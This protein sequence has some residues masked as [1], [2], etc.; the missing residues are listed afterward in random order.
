MN[1]YFVNELKASFLL[2]K[3]KSRKPT[4]IYL[5]VYLGKK[6]YKFSLKVRVYPDQWSNKK[7]KAFISNILSELDNSNNRIVNEKINEYTERF[8]NFKNYL[9]NY[10][11]EVH[12]RE[13]IL[14]RYFKN[15][16]KIW[17]NE[18]NPFT[19]MITD[20]YNRVKSTSATNMTKV[21][22][23]FEDYCKTKEI[24]TLESINLNFL[25]GYREKLK[26]LPGKRKNTLITINAV[27]NKMTVLIGALKNAARLGFFDYNM[28]NI[29]LY[30]PLPEKVKQY[31][32]QIAL[33]LEEIKRI[34]E[35][36]LTGTYKEIRDAFI[37]QSF[38]GQ[39]FGDVK[40][41]NNTFIRIK[42]DGK[43]FLQ[44][45][46]QKR[47]HPIYIEVLPPV[48]QIID[49]NM[50][51]HSP[52]TANDYLKKIA[53]LAEIKGEHPYTTHTKNG[54]ETKSIPRYKLISTH[55]ARRFFIT[56]AR[57]N[58]VP[59]N[60]IM[61]ITGLKDKDMLERYDKLSN[62]N[63]AIEAGTILTESLKKE[64]LIENNSP[65]K[66]NKNELE[67]QSIIDT[68]LLNKLEQLVEEKTLL[69]LNNNILSEEKIK[70]EKELIE[71][72]F[73]LKLEQTKRDY[74]EHEEDS[75]NEIP[76]KEDFYN[77]T[78]EGDFI[79]DNEIFKIMKSKNSHNKN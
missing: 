43:E 46:Q 25:E 27:N 38:V 17:K 55:T 54:V 10:P 14:K 58:K 21:I 34:M 69:K 48:A 62:E 59:D 5:S 11:N 39:R 50:N 77:E 35:L 66:D 56:W 65:D 70:V 47:I 30:K 37:F 74:E 24:Y 22:K 9:C 72:E 52:A 6:Q 1:Q 75:L 63:A 32:N 44:F 79:H 57:A 23:D 41:F 73:L 68:N 36:E 45:V 40:K 78:T 26:S 64:G 29:A 8:N 76:S 60:I 49:K 4:G 28:S 20:I 61:K 33:T 2:R 3:P 7:K 51:Y 53:K 18:D 42:K 71:K 31:E 13:T 15:E 19:W 67:N 12:R 16:M